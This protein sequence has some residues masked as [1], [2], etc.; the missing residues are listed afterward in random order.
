M[1]DAADPASIAAMAE[2]GDREN[3]PL[4]EQEERQQFIESAPTG[5]Q[6]ARGGQL[7]IKIAFA[8]V[9][10][11]V[12]LIVAVLAYAFFVG[13][14]SRGSETAAEEEGDPA[15]D[16][17][18]QL[19]AEN[20]ELRGA[21]GQLR[22]TRALGELPSGDLVSVK[23]NPAAADK[24]G[25]ANA[26]DTPDLPDKGI[27]VAN[28]PVQV[29]PT[30]TP[31]P[32]PPRPR[33]A[34][35]RASAVTPAAPPPDPQEIVAAIQRGSIQFS[36]AVFK[37]PATIA[38][39]PARFEVD[40][41][42]PVEPQERSLEEAAIAARV[43]LEEL[44]PKP[45]AVAA[46]PETQVL[47]GTVL[48]GEQAVVAAWNT[49]SDRPLGTAAVLLGEPLLDSQGQMVL[50]AETLLITQIEEV[51]DNGWA[52]QVAVA[53]RFIDPDT[54]QMREVPLPE[55]AIS[56][57][58]GDGGALI[59]TEVTDFD[60]RAKRT[61][62]FL[63]VL[64]GL[65]RLGDELA[66][67]SSTTTNGFGFTTTTTESNRNLGGAFLSGAGDT[68]LDNLQRRS[69][70]QDRR[71]NGRDPIFVVEA[72]TPV[73]IVVE[74]SFNLPV[75]NPAGATALAPAN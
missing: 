22:S 1:V 21:N 45:E 51:T 2:G 73:A 60:G 25:T 71:L 14:A 35:P 26:P 20:T 15:Q 17:I 72:E 64:G 11:V 56:I 3:G 47:A 16:R 38:A 69:E 36:T 68:L 6:K 5:D 42:E 31:R 4:V 63:A 32:A 7:A 43:P 27:Q 13:I 10:G 48:E 61:R 29:R 8:A 58:G 40:R 12:L 74:E 65:A 49:A 23:S 67:D 53:A 54:E 75:L 50:P 55:G 52:T 33:P 59:A 30:L 18:A 28:E 46:V 24:G 41:E 62:R 39:E 70:N 19:Q 9:G 37:Q 57:R 34:A 44:Q 66:E